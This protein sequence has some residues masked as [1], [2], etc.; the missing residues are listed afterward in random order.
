[1]QIQLAMGA[2]IHTIEVEAH[3]RKGEGFTTVRASLTQ[4]LTADEWQDIGVNY[5]RAMIDFDR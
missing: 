4:H 2:K 5:D 3:H 1:M